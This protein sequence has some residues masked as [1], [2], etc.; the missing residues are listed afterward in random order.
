M[1]NE[2]GVRKVGSRYANGE[3]RKPVRVHVVA[4]QTEAKN[5]RAAWRK[6]RQ[7]RRR[8]YTRGRQYGERQQVSVE[9]PEAAA[10]VTTTV[11]SE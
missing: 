1:A 5:G 8:N 2:G 6:C 9:Q 4:R 3:A 7:W 10:A 11:D